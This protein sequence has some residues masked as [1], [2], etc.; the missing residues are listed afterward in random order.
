MTPVEEGKLL[1]TVELLSDAVIRL[2]EAVDRLEKRQSYMAG[3][4]AAVGTMCAGIGA[5]AALAVQWFHK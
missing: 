3:A 4:L 5:L 2:T 1:T